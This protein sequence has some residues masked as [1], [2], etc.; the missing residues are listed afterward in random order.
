MV[1]GFVLIAVTLAVMAWVVW[2]DK[3]LRPP[4]L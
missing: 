4:S 1:I 3:D 2:H